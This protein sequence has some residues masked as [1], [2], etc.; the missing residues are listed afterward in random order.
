MA[1]P[2]HQQRVHGVDGQRANRL[3]DVGDGRCSR[4][5]IP[6]VIGHVRK[7]AR[8]ARPF[9][10]LHEH[11]AVVAITADGGEQYWTSLRAKVAAGRN[12]SGIVVY[13]ADCHIARQVN[14]ACQG[15]LQAQRE[16]S[17]FGGSD[18]LG[19]EVFGQ[20]D[21]F[22]LAHIL[23]I[24]ALAV[25]IAGFDDIVVNERDAANALAHQRGRDLGDDSARADTQHAAFREDLLVE[26]GNLPL[27]VFGPG[28]RFSAQANRGW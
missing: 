11:I 20:R 7:Q 22:V 15:F 16:A 26:A 3:E 27:P 6:V 24:E 10:F 14:L 4:T 28:N 5:G 12:P 23:Y 8:D 17:D 21:S 19:L 18:A 13:A 2:F 1:R 25:E 9:F